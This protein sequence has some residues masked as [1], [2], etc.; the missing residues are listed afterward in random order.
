MDT[1][2]GEVKDMYFG[3]TDMGNV[4]HVVPSLHPFYAIPT[5]AVNHSKMFTE[6]AGSE[7]AQKPTLDVSKAMAMTVIE[8]M[9]SPEILKE[10]KRNFEEDLLE[11]L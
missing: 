2:P 11:G 10:I 4:S 9:R 8:V 6:V 3:S 5:D 7:P 1:D